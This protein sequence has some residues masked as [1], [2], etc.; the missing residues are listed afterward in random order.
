MNTLQECIEEL[1]EDEQKRI[2]KHFRKY[3]AFIQLKK[4]VPWRHRLLMRLIL[5]L[6]KLCNKL[7]S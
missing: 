6:A 7:K 5:N 1:N 4:E 2:L 3:K